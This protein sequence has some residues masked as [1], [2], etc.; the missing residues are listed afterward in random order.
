MGLGV[1]LIF[2]PNHF[3]YG[4][5]FCSTR[6]EPDRLPSLAEEVNEADFWESEHGP[7]SCPSFFCASNGPGSLELAWT[8]HVPFSLSVY[9]LLE[10]QVMRGRFLLQKRGPETVELGTFLCS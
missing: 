3:Y 10:D 9:L 2:H 5:D 8:V 6:S 7:G 4:L 1:D